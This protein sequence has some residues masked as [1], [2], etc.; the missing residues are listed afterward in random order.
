LE[1]IV[2]IIAFSV[3]IEYDE[4]IDMIDTKAAS[5]TGEI[6]FT[7]PDVSSFDTDLVVT[8]NKKRREVSFQ[9]IE[10]KKKKS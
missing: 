2:V 1:R 3:T 5:S 6:S 9:L 7:L 8:D 4:L 10:K